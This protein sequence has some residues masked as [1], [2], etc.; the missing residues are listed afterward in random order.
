MDIESVTTKWFDDEGRELVRAESQ[1]SPGFD[2]GDWPEI[3]ISPL[4]CGSLA[5]HSAHDWTG[6]TTGQ[7]FHCSGATGK[8]GRKQRRAG[9]RFI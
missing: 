1:A 6:Q 8:T 9:M 7:Q 4:S 2:D 5:R 3:L